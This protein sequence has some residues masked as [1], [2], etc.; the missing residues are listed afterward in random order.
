[1][2]LT[3]F[4][5]IPMIALA[6]SACGGS[7]TASQAQVADSHFQDIANAMKI[8][9]EAS[10]PLASKITAV[11]NGEITQSEFIAAYPALYNQSQE[12]HEPVQAICSTP[13]DLDSSTDSV[14]YELATAMLKLADDVC[15]SEDYKNLYVMAAITAGGTLYQE[16]FD[17]MIRLFD[18]YTSFVVG[19]FEEFLD[20]PVVVENMSEEQLRTFKQIRDSFGS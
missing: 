19:A 15:R 9:N 13:P 8:R 10:A 5:G 20:K 1:M 17:E 7:A 18:E 12:G 3:R 16:D 4:V 2:K 11:F 14:D 6:L